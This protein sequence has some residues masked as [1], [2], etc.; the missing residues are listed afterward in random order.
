[1]ENEKAA[2]RRQ[3]R[4][5]GTCWG[6]RRKDVELVSSVR[7]D[8]AQQKICD[9]CRK[10]VHNHPE[11]DP[12]DVLHSRRQPGFSLRTRNKLIAVNSQLIRLMNSL[13]NIGVEEQVRCQIR[14]LVEPYLKP[15]ADDIWPKAP[16]ARASAP[17]SAPQGITDI[18]LHDKIQTPRPESHTNR[19]PV[20]SPPN[21]QGKAAAEEPGIDKSKGS[22]YFKARKAFNRVNHE[23]RKDGLHPLQELEP[24]EKVRWYQ[25]RLAKKQQPGRHNTAKVESTRSTITSRKKSR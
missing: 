24:A 20:Q 22:L 1:M 9:A 4:S 5:R 19:L 7:G 16:P 8:G 18:K 10:A 13:H 14:E 6:C 12:A 11:L 23:R 2:G 25:D 3:N 21:D 17:P 15:I